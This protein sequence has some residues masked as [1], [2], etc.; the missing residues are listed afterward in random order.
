MTDIDDLHEKWL[1]DPRYRA[2]YDALEE[3]FSSAAKHMEAGSR[4]GVRQEELPATPIS[5]TPSPV[6]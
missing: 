4:V 2:E 6:C 5:G 3:E 1:S